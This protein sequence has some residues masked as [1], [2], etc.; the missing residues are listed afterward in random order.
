MG[1]QIGHLTDRGRVRQLNE[2]SYL[3]L[4]PPH[5]PPK[6]SLLLVVADGMGGHHAGAVASGQV[7]ASIDRFFSGGQFQ[8]LV[9]YSP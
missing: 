1:F 7:I 2:D 5:L 4:A 3:V 9:E 6:V 8:Q